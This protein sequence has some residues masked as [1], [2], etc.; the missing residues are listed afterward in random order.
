LARHSQTF[1]NYA[2]KNVPED[3]PALIALKDNL[4]KVSKSEVEGAVLKKFVDG[5]PMNEN[6]QA[7]A[8]TLMSKGG[9]AI[10]FDSEGRPTSITVGKVDL[11]NQVVSR[12]MESLNNVQIA[13]GDFE[14]IRPLLKDSTVGL[15]GD[16]QNFIIG[17]KAQAEAFG[18]FFT[19]LR[20]RVQADINK[21]GFSPDTSFLDP[22][23]SQVRALSGLINYSVARA[24]NP[25]ERL[26]KDDLNRAEKLTGLNKSIT[27]KNQILRGM[28]ESEVALS[29]RAD[30]SRTTLKRQRVF[31]PATQSDVQNAFIDAGGDKDLAERLLVSRG[32]K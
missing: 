23:I 31:K 21:F 18:T 12:A 1:K 16:F 17:G 22:S 5:S 24:L 25:R 13:L 3:D 19:G 20:D 10:E 26:T 29:R 11:P 15:A 2:T 8:Q 30:I 27:S 7:L 9:I 14:A 28:A 32:F 6:E 4:T